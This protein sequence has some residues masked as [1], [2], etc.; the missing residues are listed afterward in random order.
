LLKIVI[1]L[2]DKGFNTSE[3]SSYLN[4][5][6]YLS[7]RGKAIKPSHIW[8]MLSKHDSRQKRLNSSLKETI[9]HIQ[10]KLE[11]CNESIESYDQETHL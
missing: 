11:T 2:R 10:I 9:D 5:N 6:G 3:I 7:V 1:N 8:N 4:R